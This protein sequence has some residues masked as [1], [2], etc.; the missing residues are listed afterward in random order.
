MSIND[1]ERVEKSFMHI[2][3]VD[4]NLSSK[5]TL[6]VSELEI[7]EERREQLCLRFALRA[8]KQPEH[9]MWFVPEAIRALYLT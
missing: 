1:L 3:L 8:A 7:L 5:N 4:N 9:N 2:V 6:K